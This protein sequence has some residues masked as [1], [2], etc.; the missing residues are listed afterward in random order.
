MSIPLCTIDETGIHKPDL[1]EVIDYLTTSFRGI[2]GSDVY[3]GNDSQDGQWLG[4]LAAAFNDANAVAV[5]VYNAFSPATAQGAGLSSVVKV[6]GI[7]KASASYSTSDLLIGGQVGATIT[8]GVA[9][10]LQGFY[11]ALPAIVTIPIDGQI[12]VTATCLTIGAVEAAANTI[13]S[14]QTPTLGWQ[15]VTN[16]STATAG[17]PV[18]TDPQ[19]RIR[20]S[21]STQLPSLSLLEG[22]VGA[23]LALSGVSRIR[24][25]ENDT[26]TTDANGLPGHSISLI[27]DGG[28]AASIAAIIA[29]KK[30]CAGT[31]GTAVQTVTDNAGVAHDIRFFRPTEPAI[32]YVVSLKAKTGYSTVVESD[33]KQSLSDWT[34]AIGIGNNVQLTRSYSAA[35]L[36]PLMQSAAAKLQADLAA[37]ADPATIAADA[38]VIATLNA[39]A[40]TFEIVSIT[41]ARDGGTPAA[42]DVDIAFN[43]APF[44]QP[45]NIAVTVVP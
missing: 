42:A 38:A 28:D 10:D 9:G 30:G 31:Y 4:I 8:N 43:E 25:Y 2:Y 22:M 40:V 41:A 27:V 3:L 12:T 33:I 19:L 18:E 14:I 7:K 23:I 34:N 35:Y 16:E 29:K 15:T 21:L 17:Q 44:C 32:T 37:E 11:W 36:Q 1:A 20:Q 26:D 39:E 6:N 24:A 45:G 5:A 13:T